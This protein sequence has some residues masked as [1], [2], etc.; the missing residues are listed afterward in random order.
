VDPV[1][2]VLAADLLMLLEQVKLLEQ[3]DLAAV[4][5]VLNV[6]FQDLVV[7]EDQVQLY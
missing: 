3:M 7:L 6:L 2:E 4:V 5:V 1:A